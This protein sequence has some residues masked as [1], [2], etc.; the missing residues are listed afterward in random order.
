M[1]RFDTVDHFLR[2]PD[3][4]AVRTKIKE[5]EKSINFVIVSHSEASSPTPKPCNC[6]SGR[7][8]SGLHRAA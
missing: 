5:E 8:R 1:L 2:A 7:A 6:R 3:P 4:R